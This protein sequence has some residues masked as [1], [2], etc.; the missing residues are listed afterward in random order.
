MHQRSCSCRTVLG[1]TATELRLDVAVVPVLQSHVLISTRMITACY[2]LRHQ[3]TT[4]AN[5]SWHLVA[6]AR[7]GAA[8]S[9]L[10]EQGSAAAALAVSEG[11]V[12][13]WLRRGR[14]SG[15]LPEQAG[16][17]PNTTLGE[18]VSSAELMR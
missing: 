17:K 18:R 11:A 2:T 9:G 12:R 7:L 6:P 1:P 8:S 3:R 14:E 13:Q 16:P 4:G 15:G 5:G 10:V